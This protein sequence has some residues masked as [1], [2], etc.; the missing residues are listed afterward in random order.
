MRSSSIG[1]TI[2]G[3]ES[4]VYIFLIGCGGG[5]TRATAPQVTVSV[6]PASAQV[7]VGGTLQL[8]ASGGGS[9]YT[10]AVNDVRGGNH[11]YG[12]ITST[13][14]YT[15]PQASPGSVTIKA[16]STATPSASGTATLTIVSPSPVVYLVSPAAFV[17]GSGDT[18]ITVTGDQFVAN[19]TVTVGET[20]LAATLVSI[21][22]LKAVVPAALL[23]Q[24]TVHRLTV[25]TP[26]PGGGADNS[27]KLTVA[28]TG[29][30]AATTHPLVAS[31]SIRL[32]RPG[33]VA[34]EFGLD[35]TYGRRTWTRSTPLLRIPEVEILVAGMKQFSTYHMR[36][37]ADFADGTQFLDADHTFT[38]GG[39]PTSRV[40]QLKV[41]RPSGL[42]NNP[43]V[44]LLDLYAGTANQALAAITDLDGNVI[45]YYDYDP[46]TWGAPYPWRP[47]A[48]GNFIILLSAGA[49]REIDLLGNTIREMTKDELNLRLAAGGFNLAVDSMH[50][51]VTP[52]PNGHFILLV[53]SHRS[54]MDLPGRP[55]E[56]KITGD[57]LVDLDANWNPVGVWNTFDHMDVNRH[58]VS[59]NDWTHGNSIA[60]SADD[61]NLLFSM[62]NQHW[63]IKID[64]Q[65]GRGS[66]NILWRL[67]YQG[68]FTMQN[69][70]PEAWQ[71]GQHF[72]VITTP[73]TTGIF[74]LVIFD[75][76]NNRV[77]DQNGTTCQLFVVPYCYS[78]AP[79]FRV[80]EGSKTVQVLFDGRLPRYADMLGSVTFFED[81]NVEADMGLLIP[82]AAQVVEMTQ[83]PV[84][85][86]V[87]QM[88][89][90]GQ[91][92]YRAYRI[93]SLY[94]GVQW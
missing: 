73:D 46:A 38:T 69:G 26:A 92:A 21:N 55:G 8:A 63:V 43:G 36:A 52:L 7:S 39:L 81:G 91:M 41:T 77:M 60:Y 80:D 22:E 54:F 51:E 68:D 89:I 45:W 86:I 79:I 2:I 23:A 34:V 16:T 20:Q 9:S 88:D 12:T 28:A 90:T 58:P 31:Y 17:A 78:R 29:T 37:V 10:W 30:V 50:H 94:P 93:P 87:W 4:I 83:E 65:D 44:E 14:L 27:H 66:G 19:S 85:Q 62:R 18:P 76:G 84:P 6:S 40:P 56:T 61:G 74:D 33:K 35:T 70:G 75:N 24:P 32:P 1:S 67:G 15:A 48:N 25:T 13:G 5:G 42:P 82:I 53:N 49:L 11:T 64:Y 71:Y 59:V 57:Q 47:L 72:P 3:I